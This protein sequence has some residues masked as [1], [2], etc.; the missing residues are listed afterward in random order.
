MKGKIGFAL[1]FLLGF[2]L[3]LVLLTND[4]RAQQPAVDK[5]KPQQPA[6]SAQN[7]VEGAYTINSRRQ[8]TCLRVDSPV[9]RAGGIN[10]RRRA[11]GALEDDGVLHVLPRN[12]E[13]RQEPSRG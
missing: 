10:G 11:C 6:A 9:S 2:M 5:D 1:L 12:G 13:L 4:A 7:R 8:N 3:G